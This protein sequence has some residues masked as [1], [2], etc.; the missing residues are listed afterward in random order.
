MQ[1]K[2]EAEELK[3]AIIFCGLM[4]GYLIFYILFIGWFKHIFRPVRFKGD[5]LEFYDNRDIDQ[6]VRNII[7]HRNP[8]GS[9]ITAITRANFFTLAETTKVY[10]PTCH[11]I[12][13]GWSNEI[14]TNVK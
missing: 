5:I 1:S 11:V 6:T 9:Q 8:P 12:H 4:Y 2:R 10:G 7:I 3:W 13:Y 14:K